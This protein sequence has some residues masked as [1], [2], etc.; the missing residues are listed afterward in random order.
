MG[1]RAIIYHLPDSDEHQ[2][3][4]SDFRDYLIFHTMADSTIH[5]YLY[6]I[7]QFYSLYSILNST[8][9][10]LYKVY[11][12]EHYKPQTVNLRIRAIN[13]YLEHLGIT[14]MRIPMIHMQ[15]KHYLDKIISEADY[16]YLKSCLKRDGEYLYY[17]IIRYMACTG[18]RV[19]ELV[20]VTTCDV[21]RGYKDLFSKG[22]KSRRIFIPS[23]L[24]DDTM[25][26]LA[27]EGRP[28]GY[29]FLNRFGDR[30]T[31]AGIRGQLKKFAARYGMNVSLVF[32]HSFR[33][34]FA[35]S[36]IEH[37]GD[38]AMLSDLL[39]H[40]SIETT[41]IYLRRSSSEQARMVN[42]I[43]DW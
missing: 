17:F 23:Q 3:D 15:Q 40:E 16:E 28:E 22:H 21:Y 1:G 26:W 12:L 25:S 34:R 31:A 11:L 39:G 18:M 33:H 10:Q 13:C 36:F 32:P 24:R 38:I 43:V 37:G 8:N 35:K 4:L 30:I 5:V 14:D 2:V 9:L 29:L 41:R 6:A 19:S 20:Q 42:E 7:E 27:R